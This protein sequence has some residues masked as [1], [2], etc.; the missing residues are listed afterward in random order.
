MALGAKATATAGR[1]GRKPMAKTIGRIG[2]VARGVV[3]CII[4]GLALR[5][6]AGDLERADNRGAL[7]T[8][9]RQPMGRVM[10]L[11]LAIGL[12]AY[13][14]S[15]FVKAAAGAAEGGSPRTGASGSA[16]RVVDALKGV[17]YA[18]L[19]A[20]ALAIAV[21][22]RSGGGTETEQEW[23]AEILAREYGRPL[24]ALAGVALV[25]VGLYLLY[26]GLS[27]SFEENLRMRSMPSWARRP[28]S[29]LGTAGYAARGVIFCLIGLFIV[30]AAANFDAEESVGVDGALKKIVERRFGPAM[31][32][33]VAL[34]LLCFGLFSFVEARYRK[35]HQA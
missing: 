28:A 7:E 20:L 15:W 13:A 25:G 29:L 2:L 14:A 6:A 22:G 24:V 21:R 35:I 12:A 30:I 27:Q 19:A 3:Y 9:L 18:G 4:A 1:V 5:I 26:R 33:V 23:T 34:G 10:L 11:V 31:L 32:V 16:L 8:I 17:M